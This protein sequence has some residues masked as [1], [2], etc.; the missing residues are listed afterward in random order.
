MADSGS[1]ERSPVA[2]RF[3]LRR[4]PTTKDEIIINVDVSGSVETSLVTFDRMSLING[5]F[6]VILS[7]V[8]VVI[9]EQRGAKKQQQ[10][11]RSFCF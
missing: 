1:G 5:Y 10:N 11:T 9:G 4:P 2:G 7:A 6:G 8:A 3:P